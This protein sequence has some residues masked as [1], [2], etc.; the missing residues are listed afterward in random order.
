MYDNG[1]KVATWQDFATLLSVAGVNCAALLQAAFGNPSAP[2][3]LYNLNVCCT[4]AC[5]L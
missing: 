5:V 4:C 2:G 1:M 3:L